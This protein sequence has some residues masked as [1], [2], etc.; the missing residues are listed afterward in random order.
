MTVTTMH[1][2]HPSVGVA[3][4]GKAAAATR[5]AWLDAAKGAGIILVVIGHALGGLI[6][7]PIGRAMPAL[8]LAFLA[9]YTFHMPLFFML[10][11][12]L[13]AQR[14]ERD[15]GRFA[16]GLARTLVWPYFLWSIVQ[17]SVI[18]AMGA[19]V[20]QPP[21]AYWPAIL[22]LPWSTL[23]QFWFLYALLLL[24][25]LAFGTLRRLGPA[26]FLLLGLALKPLMVIV[27]LPR[28]VQFA[29]SQAPYYAIG[30][31]LGAAGLERLVVARSGLVRFALLPLAAAALI[32]R[33]VTVTQSF[34]PAIPIATARA[35]GLAF[36]S[37][38]IL[39]LPAALLGAFALVAMASG[40]DGRARVVLTLLGR[41]TMP[42]FIL[43]VLVIA[44]FRIVCIH[45]LHVRD[46]I[47]ILIVGVLLGLTVPIAV[48]HMLARLRLSRPLGLA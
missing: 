19:L 29:C 33:T 31:F 22:S 26:G 18:Y 45:G 17:F 39:A 3:A 11:G 44:G 21:A 38:N 32:A 9:I 30:V 35:A 1:D 41:K 13:V 23:S 5:L 40:P 14:I 8:R 48:E 12:V 6:D 34:D 36:L 37:W 20:N 43:H 2:T 4:V 7:S 24:H 42:I 16:R 10:A 25:G 47:T 46:P 15:A 28:V 27:P